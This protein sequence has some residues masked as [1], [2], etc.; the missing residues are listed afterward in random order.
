VFCFITKKTATA[1]AAKKTTATEAIEKGQ[2]KME[3]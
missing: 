1:A 2:K 3:E